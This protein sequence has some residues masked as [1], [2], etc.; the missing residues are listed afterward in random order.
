MCR[1]N[2]AT[3]RTSP[4]KLEKT[5]FDVTFRKKMTTPKTHLYFRNV[6]FSFCSS[7]PNFFFG[8]P[9]TWR[10]RCS[11][12]SKG[13]KTIWWHF[14]VTIPPYGWYMGPNIIPTWST[15]SR[16]FQATSRSCPSHPSTYHQPTIGTMGA[17]ASAMPMPLAPGMMEGAPDGTKEPWTASDKNFEF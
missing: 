3:W 13:F 16:V 4:S 6:P 1:G 8:K 2:L 12:S 9:K 7:P 15:F 14:G 10:L 17:G 5:P 11:S